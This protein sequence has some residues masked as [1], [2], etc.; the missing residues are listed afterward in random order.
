LGDASVRDTGDSPSD[1][2]EGRTADADSDERWVSFEELAKARGVTKPSAIK[3]VRRHGWRRQRDNQGH[4]RALV[5]AAWITPEETREPDS[6][7]DGPADRATDISGIINV[8]QTAVASLTE[9]ATAAEQRVDQADGRA[10]RAEQGRTRAEERAE[11]AK[12]NPE[13]SRHQLPFGAILEKVSES[14]TARNCVGT[15]SLKA[16]VY[17]GFRASVQF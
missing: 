15:R 4:I 9:R 7:G 1:C 13:H 3:L 16:A 2:T 10:H 5:P 17:Q 8:L 14:L 6:T 11:R 12:P